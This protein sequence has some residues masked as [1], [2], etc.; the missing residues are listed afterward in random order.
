MSGAW[1]DYYAGLGR[2][3][4]LCTP[5]NQNCNQFVLSARSGPKLYLFAPELRCFVFDSAVSAMSGSDLACAAIR[6]ASFLVQK[7][8]AAR[9]KSRDIAVRTYAEDLLKVAKLCGSNGAFSADRI[10]KRD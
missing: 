6:L 7:G 4:T 9:D 3:P 5:Q 10:G 8:L 1:R 2:S